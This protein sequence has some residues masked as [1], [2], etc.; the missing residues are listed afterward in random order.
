MCD[1]SQYAGPSAAWLAVEPTIPAPPP[2]V[3]FTALKDVLNKGREEASAEAMKLFSSKVQIKDYSIPTRDGSTLEARTYISNAAEQKLH[4][5]RLRKDTESTRLPVFLYFHGGGFLF[6]TLRSEDATCSRIA[7]NSDV[8][9]VNVNYRHTPE[10][11]YPTAWY[12]SQD[13]FLWVHENASSFHGDPQKVIVSGISAGA[14]LTAS[15]TLEQHLSISCSNVPKILG[16]ILL[17]PCLVGKD[18]YEPQFAKMKSKEVSSYVENV[19]APLLPVSRVDEFTKLLKVPADLDVRDTKVNIGN[20]EEDKVK[21]MPPSVFGIAALDP[22]RDE[23]LLY[24]KMLT[25][26]G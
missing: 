4:L 18:C 15:L 11:V 19:N 26:N 24:A 1:F 23:G 9:V 8:V 7:L 25:E 12:D 17:I 6:G 3:P 5:H 14:Q 13:A 21:G 22:F 20:V 16:Q 10:H 2:D